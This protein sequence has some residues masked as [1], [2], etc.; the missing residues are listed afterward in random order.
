MVGWQ[1][2]NELGNSHGNLCYCPSCEK[3]FRQWLKQKYQTIERLNQCW[4]TAFWSQGYTS[5]DQITAPKMTTSG[6]NPSQQLDWKRFC[7]DLVLE[8]HQFQADILRQAAPASLLPTT[9]WAFRQ[10]GLSSPG[11][12]AGFRLPRSI[13]GRP[14]PCAARCVPRGFPCGGAGSGPQ[15]QE[16]PFW[17]MEQQLGDYGMG[18]SGPD[19][20]PRTAGAVGPCNASPTARTPFCFSAGAPA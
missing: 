10:A 1:V 20:P 7:S 19:A 11:R 8:F 18:N 6:H 15:R 12:T 4:G 13:S 2:D 17:I 16:K 9:S 14:F 5:F 3:R